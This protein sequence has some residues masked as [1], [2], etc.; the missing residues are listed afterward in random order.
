ME[1][2]KVWA[3]SDNGFIRL[4]DSEEKA[5]N[6]YLA[7]VESVKNNSYFHLSAHRDVKLDMQ[8]EDYDMHYIIYTT[9]AQ[10]G[11]HDEYRQAWYQQMKIN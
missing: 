6:E 7:I 5:R 8:V 9:K 4:Y 2:L 3:V 1:D 11:D 10:F